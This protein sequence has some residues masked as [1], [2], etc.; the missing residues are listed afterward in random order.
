MDAKVIALN[1]RSLQR[2]YPR[3]L[4]SCVECGSRMFKIHETDGEVMVECANC[5]TFIEFKDIYP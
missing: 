1:G 5:E 3:R 2:T 4:F